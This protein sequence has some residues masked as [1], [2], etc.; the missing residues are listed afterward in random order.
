M[1]HAAAK[2]GNTIVGRFFASMAAFSVVCIP[3]VSLLHTTHCSVPY[4][5]KQ[6]DPVFVEEQPAASF[7]SRSLLKNSWDFELVVADS[8]ERECLEEQCSYEEAREVFED[9]TQTELFW[10]DYVNN[11]ANSPI[12]DVSGLVAG[13]L[14]VLVS[15]V[16]ATVLGIYCY[17]AKNKGGQRA[18]VRMAT[19][20]H[21]APE[22]VPLAGITAPGLPSYNEALNRSGQHDAPP[23]PYSGGAPSEPADPGEE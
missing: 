7:L 8:L 15:A 9:D 5:H 18:P 4:R 14:A 16:I 20:M 2:L 17:K 6:G 11:Q 3:L 22:M 21:P 10:T 1:V 19:D 23:P 12:V 13:I